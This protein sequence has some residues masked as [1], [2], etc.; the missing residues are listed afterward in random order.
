MGLVGLWTSLVPAEG[1]VLDWI[2]FGIA[3][4]GGTFAEAW[5]LEKLLPKKWCGIGVRKAV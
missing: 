5:L 3:G 4:T 1:V 2:A